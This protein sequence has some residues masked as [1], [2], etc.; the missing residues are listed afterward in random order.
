MKKI[1][2]ICKNNLFYQVL[3]RSLQFPVRL[4]FHDGVKQKY[5]HTEIVTYLDLQSAMILFQLILT[6]FGEIDI[7]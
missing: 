7:F 2:C 6:T 1:F 5:Q 3:I 4:V